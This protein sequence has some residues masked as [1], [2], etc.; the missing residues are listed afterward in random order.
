MRVAVIPTDII[1]NVCKCSLVA[2][3]AKDNPLSRVI[4]IQQQWGLEVAQHR[5]KNGIIRHNMPG[6]LQDMTTCA[7]YTGFKLHE[8]TVLNY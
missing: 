1:L 8:T 6:K 3:I 4:S 2:S 7:E 5:H